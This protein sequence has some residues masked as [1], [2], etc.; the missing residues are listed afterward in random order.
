VDDIAESVKDMHQF[1]SNSM[2]TE[3]ARTYASG[4][5]Q[6]FAS[7]HLLSE[8]CQITLKVLQILSLFRPSRGR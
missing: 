3:A 7:V 5:M 6:Q 1:G 4:V 2:Q 8:C